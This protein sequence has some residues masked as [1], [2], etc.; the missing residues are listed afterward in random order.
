MIKFHVEKRSEEKIDPINQVERYNILTQI[1]PLRKFYY[2][3]LQLNFVNI[4]G[5]HIC[6]NQPWIL[7]PRSLDKFLNFFNLVNKYNWR[8]IVSLKTNSFYLVSFGVGTLLRSCQ[9]LLFLLQHTDEKAFFLYFLFFAPQKELYLML[10]TC[11]SIM[12]RC[13]ICERFSCGW[14]THCSIFACCSEYTTNS[15]SLEECA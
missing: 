8:S 12:F 9:Y 4:G 11:W 3:L 13:R 2:S 1:D 10:T 15:P 7:L 5:Y 14:R 6:S